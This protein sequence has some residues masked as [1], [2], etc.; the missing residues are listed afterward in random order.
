MCRVKLIRDKM[1]RE[2]TNPKIRS[3]HIAKHGE[4]NLHNGKKLE[5]WLNLVKCLQDKRGTDL[6]IVE[7]G[8][9]RWKEQISTHHKDLFEKKGISISKYVMTDIEDGLDVDVA[10]DVHKFNE[11]FAE[12]SIDVIFSASTFEHFKYPWVASHQ[13][14]KSLKVNGLIFIQTHQTFALHGYPYDFYRFSREALNSLFPKE[15]GFKVINTYYEFLNE[16]LPFT[17]KHAES[18]ANVNLIGIKVAST[19]KNWII[20]L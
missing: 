19:P 4:F 15:M 3:E 16:I 18:Y 20:S 2:I 7:L 6:V 11:K 8:T 14:M 9:K 1:F 17:N 12:E 10:V 5:Y 13:L